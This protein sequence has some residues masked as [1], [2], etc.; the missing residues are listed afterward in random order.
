MKKTVKHKSKVIGIVLVIAVLVAGALLYK[1]RPSNPKSTD[2]KA[3]TPNL[4]ADG[5]NYAPAT[6]QEKENVNN[7]KET[8]SDPSSNAPAPEGRVVISSISPSNGE[9]VVKTEL[10]SGRWTQCKLV[11]TQ[12]ASSITRVSDVIYQPDFSTCMGFSIAV[13]DFPSGGNWNFSLQT[14]RSDGTI[15]TAEKTSNVVK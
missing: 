2:G 6:D 14:T 7:I 8:L 15:I 5:I 4:Q 13:S 9:M 12:G 3:D 11:A 10:Y 1:N